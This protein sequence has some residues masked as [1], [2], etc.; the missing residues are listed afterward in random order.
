MALNTR[1]RA[2]SVMKW[3]GS[4]S[5]PIAEMDSCVQYCVEL[6]K[7][8]LFAEGLARADCTRKIEGLGVGN[9]GTVLVGSGVVSIGWR[10]QYKRLAER[11]LV[12]HGGFHCY[13]FD[14][15]GLFGWDKTAVS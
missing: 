6:G 2:D 14:Y 9:R 7:T 8:R 3:M 12:E 4:D 13:K 10:N 15:S 11:P 5:N 1:S